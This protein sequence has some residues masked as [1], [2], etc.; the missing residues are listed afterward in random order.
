MWNCLIVLFYLIVAHSPHRSRHLQGLDP[1]HLPSE[2]K[3]SLASSPTPVNPPEVNQGSPSY[4]GFDIRSEN[5]PFS[6]PIPDP[7]GIRIVRS[8]DSDAVR[9]YY[10]SF[11]FDPRTPVTIDDLFAEADQLSVNLRPT[12]DPYLLHFNQ[13]LRDPSRPIVQQLTE[14]S[15]SPSRNNSWY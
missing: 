3:T 1:P 6:T 5:N 2:V 11:S 9:P 13:P 8:S 10:S 15:V 7:S 12:R 14:P 4:S